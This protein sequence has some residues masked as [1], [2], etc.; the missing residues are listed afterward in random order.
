MIGSF[1]LE[2]RVVLPYT[3]FPPV[4]RQAIISIEDKTFERNWGVNLVRAVGAAWRDLHSRS[5]AQ[6]S[7]T[8]TMQLARNFFLSIGEDL[9]A[10]VPGDLCLSVQIERRVHE[11]PDL[12]RCM[13]TRSTWGMGLT[14]SRRR[15]EYYFSKHAQDLTLPEAALLAAL[16][17]GAGVLFA[18]QLSGSRAA[19]AEPG[20]AARCARTRR[21]RAAQEEAATAAPLGLHIEPPPNSLHRTLWRRCGGSWRRSLAPRRC[22]A[23]GCGCI[24]RSIS[25]C[26]SWRIR[27]CSM[28]RRHTSGGMGGRDICRMSCCRGDRSGEV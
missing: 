1:A 20:A 18:D 23:R 14:G 25:T 19:A 26:R 15:S 28:A 3:E 16:P 8:L 27:R 6:G 12:R 10:E 21:L 2:R 22:M 13:R 4:L 11:G 9:W 5:R 17:K 24:R 7:S